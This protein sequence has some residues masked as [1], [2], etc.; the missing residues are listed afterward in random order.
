MSHAL[1]HL[2]LSPLSGKIT[3]APQQCL[4]N[5]LEYLENAFS[6]SFPHLVLMLSSF[7]WLSKGLSVLYDRPRNCKLVNI[8]PNVVL[9]SDHFMISKIILVTDLQS[10]ISQRFW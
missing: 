9:L 4:T 6:L 3:I 10:T 2:D 7:S 1:E 5:G 8:M